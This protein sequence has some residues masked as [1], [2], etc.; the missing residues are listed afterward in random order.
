MQPTTVAY[1]QVE[2]VTLF[3][4]V[5]PPSPQAQVKHSAT[6]EQHAA[7]VFF[8]AGG[9]ALGDRKTWFPDWLYTRAT[10][11]GIVFISADYR[12]LPAATGHEILS[13]IVDVF[14]FVSTSL[15]STL[16]AESGAGYQIDPERVA[17]AGC[18]AGAMSAF[19]AA[20][21]A[22]PK[23]KAILSMYGLG[24][25]VFSPQYLVPKTS[26]FFM[27]APL[28]DPAKF[29]H[30]IHPASSSV[31]PTGSLPLTGPPTPGP[32]SPR[33]MLYPFYL[34]IGTYLDYWTGIHTPSLSQKLRS[35][36][37]LE[38]ELS[39]QDRS[40]RTARLS[41]ALPEGA[42]ALFPQLHVSSAWP[43]TMFVHGDADSI[44]H[45]HESR[46]MY[47]LVQDR[48]G[49]AQIIV[50]PGAEHGFDRDA[51]AEKHRAVL[52]EAFEF[53]RKKLISSTDA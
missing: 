2:E 34:Q 17:V 53:V 51:G 25:D 29:E 42:R 5:Y 46:F 27:G 9:F 31:P 12:L 14:A 40:E 28:F 49:E 20:L 41:E 7:I 36:V 52:D 38:G 33:L 22:S 30:F 48:G 16:A 8:H 39:A 45:L 44:V 32:P 18:S 19:L 21:Y 10:D 43:P 23:P 24:G 6:P 35:L 50:V 26:P 3:I 47:G 37:P 1:K 15:N 11:A 13:D 4:D